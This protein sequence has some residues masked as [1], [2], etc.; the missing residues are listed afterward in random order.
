MKNCAV[1]SS[2]KQGC[3][4]IYKDD[5]YMKLPEHVECYGEPANAVNLKTGTM[6]YFSEDK[7]IN[8]ELQ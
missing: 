8:T 6:T 4:F 7:E 1:F 3:K 2:L 5:P